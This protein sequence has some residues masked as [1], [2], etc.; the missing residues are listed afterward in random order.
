MI[1]SHVCVDMGIC[2]ATIE[3]SAFFGC[4]A[5]VVHFFTWR[6][7]EMKKTLLLL[8]VLILLFTLV[9]C[10]TET[11]KAEKYCWSCGGG[12]TKQAVF[13]E[14]CGVSLKE[15][16][17]EDS[18]D[19]GS[20]GTTQPSSDESTGTGTTQPSTCNHNWK[21]ATCTTPKICEK[22]NLTEGEANGHWWYEATCTDARICTV[23]LTEDP[24]SEPL[25]HSYIKGECERCGE[26]ESDYAQPTVTADKTNLYIN[27]AY[28]VVYLTM[29]GDGAIVYD[30]DNTQIVDCQ[31]GD[32]DGN[33]IPL[34]FYPVSSGETYVTVYPEGYDD[35]GITIYVMVVIDTPSE[36]T[37]LT[38]E[39]EGNE[40]KQYITGLPNTNK[41]H[42]V[43]YEIEPYVDDEICIWIDYVVSCIDCVEYNGY[44]RIR[45]NLYNSSGVVVETGLTITEFTHT[46]TQYAGTMVFS[47]LPADDYT[48]VFSDSY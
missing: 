27:G 43:T 45:Y 31:W 34:T 19:D 48:L 29:I 40:F 28:Q 9:A 33:T 15:N 38:I 24:D 4:I 32:W 7:I 41:L 36:L 13:C 30:I 42:S 25:G 3:T 46:N 16:S 35:K 14:H 18:S 12:V 23:C 22:C 6:E 10:G 20:T 39:G 37:T 5:S 44:I 17:S 8:I 21:N 11:P 26:T 2:V 1:F 47:G